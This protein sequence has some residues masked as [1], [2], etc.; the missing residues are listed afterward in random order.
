MS[1]T[2]YQILGVPETAT[3]AEID[4]AFKSKATEVH[5]DRISGDS[6]YLKKVAAE[7]FKNLSE[8]KAVLLDPVKRRQYDRRRPAWGA[9]PPPPPPA[10]APAPA[11]IPKTSSPRYE[12]VLQR[13]NPTWRHNLLVFIAVCSLGLLAAI[14]MRYRD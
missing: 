13:A 8:A 2:Y 3:P 6:S 9:S 4:A 7:A 11:S 14:A 12:R 5:P 1:Q 10:P